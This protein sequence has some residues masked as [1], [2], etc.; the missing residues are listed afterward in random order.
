MND[1]K[2]IKELKSATREE[3]EELLGV[4]Q[5]QQPA[6]PTSTEAFNQQELVAACEASLDILSAVA[7]PVGHT[8]NFPPTFQAVWVWLVTYIHKPRD[9]SKLALGL[10][11]GFGKTAIMKLFVLYCILFTDRK[12][13]LII[14]ANAKLAVNIIADVTDFLDTPN[15]KAMFGDWRLGLEKDT[16]ELK[17]FG[18]RGRNII[19]AA[20]GESGSPRGLNIKN[21]RP[22]VIIFDD[23]QTREDANS[24]VVSEDM[25]TK[26]LGTTMKAKAP[27]GCMYLFLAN[28]YPTKHS[29]LRKLKYNPKW[30]KFIAGGILA[31]GTSLWEEVQPLSQLLEEFESDLEAG[32]PELFYS[33]VLNDETAS[34]NTSIDISK[35]PLVDLTHEVSVGSFIIIDPSNDKNNSDNVSIGYFEM[36]AGVPVL[37]ELIDDKLSPSNIIRESLKLALTHNCFLIVAEANAF[38]YSL[39]HWFQVI[40]TQLGIV[41]IKFEPIYS[42]VSSKNTRIIRMFKQLTCKP[43]PELLLGPDVRSV[44][45]S[46]ITMFNPLRSDNNDNVLDVLTYAPR[47]VQELSHLI[48]LSGELQIDH[49]AETLQVVEESGARCP[50]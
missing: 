40:A 2:V 33:E 1:S 28:M 38:Q 3:A 39:L 41:G 23:I 31:D 6:D 43:T 5:A 45:L 9:F 4:N 49:T 8:A 29:I 14:A 48:V 46:Y 34:V 27:T 35:I 50:W 26:M 12:F 24:Q 18:F 30:D 44:V 17:K 11:R 37:V 42:G 21:T 15:I 36:V 20:I 16:Q 47:V 7:N 22:D 32:H 25:F 10:P 13:I 19:L